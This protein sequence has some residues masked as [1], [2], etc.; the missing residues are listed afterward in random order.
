MSSRACTLRVSFLRKQLRYTA[1]ALL[2][3]QVQALSCLLQLKRAQPCTLLVL[4]ALQ[5]LPTQSPGL[6]GQLTSRTCS[7][8]TC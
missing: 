5:K 6:L 8:Q 7:V 4:I 3:Q 2:M 1:A